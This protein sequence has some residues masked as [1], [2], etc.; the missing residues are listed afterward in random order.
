[1]STRV[2]GNR[3][4]RGQVLGLSDGM[5]AA[6]GMRRLRDAAGLT[7]AELGGLLGWTPDMTAR[8]ETV[9]VRMTPAEAEA[10]AGALGTDLAGLLAA[11]RARA[12]ETA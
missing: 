11:G 6:T 7:R 12:E 2:S 1:M 4:P 8:R 9:A 10:A 5:A 3:P